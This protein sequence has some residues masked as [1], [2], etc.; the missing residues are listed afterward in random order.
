MAFDHSFTLL[1][2]IHLQLIQ[3]FFP[4]RLLLLLLF[5]IEKSLCAMRLNFRYFRSHSFW[6][7]SLHFISIIIKMCIKS[8]AIKLCA[9]VISYM[10]RERSFVRRDMTYDL[11]RQRRGPNQFLAYLERIVLSQLVFGYGIGKVNNEVPTTNE[12]FTPFNY[13]KLYW[14]FYFGFE[15]KRRENKKKIWSNYFSFA[16]FSCAVP[17]F[18][19]FCSFL[20][21]AGCHLNKLF[22]FGTLQRWCFCTWESRKSSD[23]FC[24][25]ATRMNKQSFT[26]KWWRTTKRKE[27]H[28][29][30]G[31]RDQKKKK[32]YEMKC[33]PHQKRTNH[34]QLTA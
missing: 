4:R 15:Q 21:V 22:V 20:I 29:V 14:Y 7:I 3:S 8:L 32:L 31:V 23:A 9:M 12:I 34:A 6:S 33:T 2:K 1:P 26:Q 10:S 18:F 16:I 19:F 30:R 13:D 11:F 25:K 28:S 27:K 17:F 5:E 24:Y